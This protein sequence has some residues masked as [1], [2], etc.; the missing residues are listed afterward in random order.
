MK[1]PCG[2]E[3]GDCAD[4]AKIGWQDL[5]DAQG[6]F[7][8]IVQCTCRSTFVSSVVTD[9]C[10]CD[11]CR[12][13]VTGETEDP[14]VWS[15]DLEGAPRILCGGC[16]RR[17]GIGVQLVGLVFRTWI[18]TGSRQALQEWRAMW[19]LRRFPIKAG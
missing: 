15:T 19:G 7:G 5:C 1:C 14:K 3:H 17:A 2:L 13:L 8:L 10:L 12:R 4:L 11:Q 16:A 6:G 9:A 18:E